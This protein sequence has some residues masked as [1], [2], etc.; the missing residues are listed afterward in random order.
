[1]KLL[2]LVLNNFKGIRHF[3]LD[4]QG[5]NVSVFGDNAT[6]K[7]TLFDAITWLLFDKD[8]QNKKDFD[9]KTLDENNQPYHHLQHEVEGVFEDKGKEISLKKSYY[10]KWTKK[11]GAAKEE[12][13]GHTTDYY[14]DGVPVKKKEYV[15]LVASIADENIFKLLTNPLYF[16]T[17]LHW[18]KRR[19]M[20]TEVCGDITDEDVIASDKALANLPEVLNGRKMGDHKK[21]IK[22]RQAKINDELK[23]IPIRIDEVHRTM[24]DISGIDVNKVNQEINSLSKLA[25]D[26]Q[27]QISRIESGGEV[28]EK[29]KALRE[30]ESQLLDIK[31]QRRAG[32][33]AQISERQTLLNTAKEKFYATQG[34]IRDFEYSITLNNN[35]K[36]KLENL[37]KYKRELWNRTN[38]TTFTFNQDDT[39]PTCGQALPVDELEIAREKAQASFNLN[40]SKELESITKDGQ[41][42]KARAGE[43]VAQNV[44]LIKK[45]NEARAKLVD[46]EAA[47][48]VLQSEIETL[49]KAMDDYTNDPAYI[50][51]VQEKQGLE[52]QI[53]ALREN[54]YSEIEKIRNEITYLTS[55]IRTAEKKLADVD[56]CEK[57][58][59][60]IAELEAQEKE[61][62]AEYEKLEGELYLC[63]QFTQSKVALLEEK[64]NKKFKFARFKMFNKLVNGGIE[65]CCETIYNGVPYSSLNNAAKINIGLDIINTL[66]E[67]YGFAPVIFIDN[68][69]AVVETI[70]VNGQVIK[71][72]VS[73]ADKKLR[74]ESKELKEA[75]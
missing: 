11:R 14:I 64:I 18:E 66:S 60:R 45:L 35:E 69:E 74:V 70:P 25:S 17:Q 52:Y 57:G 62:A 27:A 34:C 28:A 1:M 29:T 68:A 30:V 41:E 9:I 42:L 4:T 73:G 32:Y 16:N 72:I 59:K 12:F 19:E 10:E 50:Q 23:K 63:E 21:V 46:E 58:K 65:D 55:D 8:S 24:P 31:T 54:R 49:R 44:D 61:L 39:C 51:K 56:A 37:M 15:D 67:H 2:Q 47:V 7:T 53:T 22:S 40:K 48:T 43:L 5:G 20:L 13:T 38:E 26:K 71:L 6:G 3:V 36:E 33:D 75:V